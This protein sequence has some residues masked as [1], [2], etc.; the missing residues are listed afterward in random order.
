VICAE[1]VA[2]ALVPMLGKTTAH[3]VVEDACRQALA[4]D[5]ALRAVLAEDPQVTALLSADAL[6][7]LCDPRNATGLADQLIQRALAQH[8]GGAL[9]ES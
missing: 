3:Q 6:D 7:R 2:M 8:A 5:V 4:Q 1:A 9:N